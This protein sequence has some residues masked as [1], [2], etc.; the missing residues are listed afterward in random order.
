MVCNS[1]WLGV[2]GEWLGKKRQVRSLYNC[3]LVQQGGSGNSVLATF[4]VSYILRLWW[5][6][7]CVLKNSFFSKTYEGKFLNSLPFTKPK[8]NFQSK[9]LD[10]Y[11]TLD[12]KQE[13]ALPGLESR[14]APHDIH[15]LSCQLLCKSKPNEEDRSNVKDRFVSSWSTMWYIMLLLII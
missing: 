5:W 6:W 8:T 4:K 14:S 9:S 1:A 2:N 11:I 12:L 10:P 15:V 13:G 7:Y 3:T